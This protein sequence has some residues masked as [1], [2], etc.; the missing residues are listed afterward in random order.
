VFGLGGRIGEQVRQK[1]GWAYYAAS[2]LDGGLGP[3]AW[4]VYAGVNPQ[5]VL[6]TVELI[7]KEIKRLITRKVT[8]AELADNQTY[9]IGRLPLTLETNAGVATAITNIEL[10][11]LGLDYLQRYPDLIRSISRDDILCVAR[12]FLDAD[13]YALA[14]AGPEV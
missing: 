7:R 1:N 14:I 13:N 6:S 12:E 11:A 8:P 4:R 5:Y 2:A 3:G 9:F 10:H